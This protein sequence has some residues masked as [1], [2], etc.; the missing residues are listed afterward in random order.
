MSPSIVLKF[1]TQTSID[2]EDISESRFYEEFS[3]LRVLQNS[4]SIAKS[5]SGWD[6]VKMKSKSQILPNYA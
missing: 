3:I 2:S 5:Q 4:T 6:I 1:E